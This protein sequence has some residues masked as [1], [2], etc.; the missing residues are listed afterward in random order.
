MHAKRNIFF[1]V[2]WTNTVILKFTTGS[3]TVFPK[4]TRDV[5]AYISFQLSSCYTTLAICE[6]YGIQ[7]SVLRTAVSIEICSY[8][9]DFAKL[10]SSS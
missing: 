3:S 5:F 4:N 7:K 2:V 6:Q 9:S 1:F 8:I 10:D